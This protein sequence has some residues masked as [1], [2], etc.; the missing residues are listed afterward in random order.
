MLMLAT[1]ASLTACDEADSG[2]DQPATTGPAGSTG[3]MEEP[4]GDPM[5]TTSGADDGD[6]D[7]PDADGPT[8]PPPSDEGT[9]DDGT[10]TDDGTAPPAGVCGDGI[11]DAGESCDDANTEPGDGCDAQCLIEVPEAW[12]CDPTFYGTGDGCDCGCGAVDADCDSDAI[13]SCEYCEALCNFGSGMCPG[14]IDPD[15][16]SACIEGECGN[17]TIDAFEACDT[18]AVTG[19]C[20]DAGFSGGEIACNATCDNVDFSGCTTDEEVAEGWTCPPSYY[21]MGDGCDCGC[22]VV[23]PDCTDEAVGSCEFCNS[24]GSCTSALAECPVGINET[25]NALCLE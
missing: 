1:L 8:D 12:N 6:H 23:D 20:M 18:G 9:D 17:G 5:G 25:N 10:G 11:V 13:E 22:G 19:A 3:T 24:P 15:D 21:G 16:I 2:T 4:D 7:G 14:A